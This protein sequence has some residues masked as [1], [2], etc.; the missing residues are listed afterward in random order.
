MVLIY[1]HAEQQNRSVIGSVN[2]T[3]QKI[4]FF[5]KFGCDHLADFMPIVSLYKTQVIQLANYLHVP[6]KII[7]KAPSP[8]LLPGLDDFIGKGK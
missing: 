7:K 3:E 6:E 2:K 1:Y 4:G 5:V 8:D